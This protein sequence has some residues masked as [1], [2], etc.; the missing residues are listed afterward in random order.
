MLKHFM[1]LKQ[2]KNWGG[3]VTE[4]LPRVF[5][6]SGLFVHFYYPVIFYDLQNCFLTVYSF[7]F[8]SWY[9][10]LSPNLNSLS[11]HHQMPALNVMTTVV[12]LRRKVEHIVNTCLLGSTGCLWSHTEACV[13][14][15]VEIWYVSCSFS[16]PHLTQRAIMSRASNDNMQH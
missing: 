13:C 8:F 1:N 4:I 9:L 14:L 15:E 11:G 7:L 12:P 5:I 6:P 3:K 10:S 2:E 16:S